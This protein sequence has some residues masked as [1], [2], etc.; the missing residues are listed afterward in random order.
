VHPPYTV[1]LKSMQGNEVHSA[2]V[3]MPRVDSL[4][5]ASPDTWYKLPAEPLP[6]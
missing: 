1:A 3:D 4:E 5:F 2:V 6:D